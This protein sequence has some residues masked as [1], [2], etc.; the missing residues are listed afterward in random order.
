[1]LYVPGAIRT[2]FSQLTWVSRDG[3]RSLVDTASVTGLI[4]GLALSP[5]GSAVALE[6]QRPTDPTNLTRI[7]VKQLD[8]GPTQLVTSENRSSFEPVWTPDGR[9]LLFA[10]GFGETIHRRR[11][12]GSGTDELVARVPRAALG[13]AIHPD[14][15]TL[16]IRGDAVNSRRRELLKIRLGIDSVPTPLF[17][18]SGGES[19]P[20]FSP[21]GRWLAYVSP[22]SGRPEVYV[23]PFPEVDARKIQ[24]S[25][26]GGVAPRW[27]PAGGELFY[28]SAAG[29]MMAARLEAAPILRVSG[30]TRLFAPQ[31]FQGNNSVLIYQVNPDGR[32]FLMLDITAAPTDAASERLVVVQN[33]GAELAKR[34]PQ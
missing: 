29:D 13:L 30:V 20:A 19:S 26:D 24:I 23:R 22:E 5:D 2:G 17:A 25:I 21:D 1:V 18:S 15:R 34:L 9:D 7:W 3:T 6:I 31:G 28:L 4:N 10:A 12:D 32:R 8:R 11:A 33:I 16:V 27:N 14:G